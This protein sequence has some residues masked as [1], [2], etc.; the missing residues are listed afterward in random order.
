M[1]IAAAGVLTLAL[2][3]A[4]AAASVSP[5]Q[6]SAQQELAQPGYQTELPGEAPAAKNADHNR[7]EGRHRSMLAPPAPDALAS[8]ASI[9][10]WVLLAVAILVL[11]VWL[12]RE[13]LGFSAAA[14]TPRAPAAERE[15]ALRAVVAQP[16]AD[17]EAL[18]AA[19]RY[20]EAIHVLL[21]R[22]L[23]ALVQRDRIDLPPSLTSREVVAHVRLST[24]ADAALRALVGAVEVSHFGGEV[25][26]ATDWERCLGQF[27]RFAQ[28]FGGGA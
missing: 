13:L 17:A 22:T 18:A 11:I 1:S 10:L 19:G 16:L 14:P 8:L 5:A 20:G 25:P 9:L 23:Q 27:H 28:V 2:L 24:D 6:T 21:L 7:T 15:A 3:G 4:P 26:G 12:L